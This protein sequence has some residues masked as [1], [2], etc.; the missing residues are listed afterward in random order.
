MNDAAPV[1][2]PDDEMERVLEK[3]KTYGQQQS[4]PR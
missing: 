1:I 4:A 3:F 2:L